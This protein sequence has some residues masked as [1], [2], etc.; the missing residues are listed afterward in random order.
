MDLPDGQRGQTLRRG[1][2][3]ERSAAGDRRGEDADAQRGDV[4][5]RGISGE[6]DLREGDPGHVCAECV[7]LCHR[8]PTTSLRQYPHAHRPVGAVA[9]RRQSRRRRTAPCAG[10][11]G[12]PDAA[13][14]GAGHP[15]KL[16][17]LRHGQEA[18]AHQGDLPLPTIRDDE[19][20]DRPRSGRL[21]EERT[22]MAFP[23]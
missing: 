17:T 5:R 4:V 3:G 12:E 11:G 22:D 16:H 15:A 18:P 23:G 20:D 2:S 1:L 21:S 14:S 7:L 6:R 13:R 19:Q 9:R 10:H 8:R